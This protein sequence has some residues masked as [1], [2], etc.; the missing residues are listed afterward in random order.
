MS[1][2]N[3]IG[4]AQAKAAKKRRQKALRELGNLVNMYEPGSMQ[5]F[6]AESRLQSLR[7][8][9]ARPDLTSAEKDASFFAIL[10]RGV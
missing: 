10:N 1:T 7:E 9:A 8:T 3:L 4:G 6:R 5:R 2:K